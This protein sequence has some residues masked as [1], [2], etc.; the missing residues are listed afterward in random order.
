MQ[1]RLHG[2]NRQHDI[3]IPVYFKDVH[4]A[5]S[6]RIISWRLNIPIGARAHFINS[7]VSRRISG[8]IRSRS[9]FSVQLYSG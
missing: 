9:F 3:A 7:S 2:P 5:A 8:A 6:L 1:L 4:A